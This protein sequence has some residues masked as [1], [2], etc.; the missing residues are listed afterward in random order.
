MVVGYVSTDGMFTVETAGAR[1]L[2]GSRYK[3]SSCQTVGNRRVYVV[4]ERSGDVIVLKFVIVLIRSVETVSIV[5]FG[6]QGR[7]CMLDDR[8]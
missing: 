7:L 4:E 8:A 5:R 2:Y 1:A 6:M 3:C